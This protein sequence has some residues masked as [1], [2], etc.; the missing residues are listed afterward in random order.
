MS[1]RFRGIITTWG[2]NYALDFSSAGWNTLVGI[3]YLEYD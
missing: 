1:R 2:T 3:L